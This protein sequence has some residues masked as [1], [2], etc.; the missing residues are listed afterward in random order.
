MAKRSLEIGSDAHVHIAN[1]VIGPFS[2]GTIWIEN[3]YNIVAE[4]NLRKGL[5]ATFFQQH[6]LNRSDTT[7]R[8]AGPVFRLL[9]LGRNSVASIL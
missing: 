7:D 6:F 5:P 3:V 9:Q 8:P 4:G 2:S 1:L